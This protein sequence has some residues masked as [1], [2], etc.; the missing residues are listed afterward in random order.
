MTQDTLTRRALRTAGQDP[1]P[2]R[3]MGTLLSALVTVAGALGVLAITWLA[4]SAV[5]GATL[6]VFRTGS[7]APAMPQGAVAVTMP[8]AAAAIEP[9]DVVTVERGRTSLPVTH[10]VVSVALPESGSAARE[11][12]LKGDANVGP[13]RQP[14]VVTETQ[15]VVVAVPGLGRV[16]A[17]AQHPLALGG[18]TL[19][20]ATFVVWAFWPA[21]PPGE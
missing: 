5:T 20:S 10:R 6:V 21:R 2:R 14:Y 11:L 18:L 9:G 12:V 7:M 4:F 13:D 1:R 8:I 17:A 15:R 3:R 19:A 16:I